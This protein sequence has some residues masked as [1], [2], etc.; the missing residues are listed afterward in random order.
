MGNGVDI[1][2]PVYNAYDEL[3]ICLESVYKY[4]NLYENRLILIND[5][6]SEEK[7]KPYLDSQQ[8]ENVF[9][10]HNEENKGFSNN[11][12]LGMA[13]SANR[14]VILLNSDTVVTKNWVEKIVKCAYSDRS[15][16]T[17]TPLSNN[18]TLCSVPNFC[19][20]NTLPEGMTIDQ[21]AAIVEEC[22]L[23]KYPR[24]TV[25][26]GFCM[27]VKREVINAIGNF[28]AEAFGRGYGE[29]NDFCNRAEQMG[30]IHVMCDDTYIYHSGTKSFVSKEKEA[31]IKEHDRILYKRY[32]QQMHKNSLHCQENPNGWVGENIAFHFDIWNGKKNIL[33]LL[34]SDFREG[35]DDNVGGT[36]LHVKHLTIGLCKD[37]NVFVAARNKDYLQVT[38]YV[39]DKE[40]VFR[41]HIG[42]KEMFPVFHDRK[43]AEIFRA[44][45]GCFRID[46]VHVHHTATT[47][48]DIYYEADR[49]GIPILFTAHDFYY[50]CPNEKLLDYEGNI[51]FEKECT[52][53]VKCLNEKKGI[54]EKNNYLSMWRK[55]HGEILGMCK[56]IFTPS[57][58][59]KEILS[60]FYPEITKK[61]HVIEHGMDKQPTLLV[62][63]GQIIYTDRLEWKIEK[64]DKRKRCP[65]ICGVAYIKYDQIEY[66]KVILKISDNKGKSIY[67][68][69]TY[70]K[71]IDVLKDEN[72]FYAYLPYTI[73][74]GRELC[75]EL[76]LY[77]N[78]KYY[79][80]KG[81]KQILKGLDFKRNCNYKVAFIGGL[82]E[83]KGAG[84]VRDI[85]KKGSTDI[86]WYVLGGIGETNL[87][88][89]KQENLIKTGYYYQEDLN[90]W[91]EYYKIDAICI[92][93]KWPE[94]F[95]YTLSEAVL[96]GIPVIATNVGALGQRTIDFGYGAVIS[97]EHAVEEALQ[98]IEAWKRRKITANNVEVLE[99]STKHKTTKD[100]LCDYKNEYAVYEKMNLKKDTS[101]II[102]NELIKNALC[103]ESNEDANNQMLVQ[104][105]GELQRHINKIE[106][107]A[108]FKVMRRVY[109]FNIPFKR[110][111]RNYILKH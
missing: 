33:Y 94:T 75:I 98:Y 5:N 77:K 97:L 82:N 72:R 8:K 111:I 56:H 107:S 48:L 43:L 6:S 47:S 24:I 73:F 1:I 69:T 99:I 95:S 60:K 96:N 104:K 23:K 78:N 88:Q 59:A 35:A 83:E 45:L 7:I 92:L 11:I 61:I 34:Q 38:A 12:N 84:I 49:L 19:E 57:N 108:A 52:D 90:T 4:T 44:I 66:G 26:H 106:N 46:I 67:L 101:F 40:H 21:A 93:S 86:E 51:C 81:K 58:S 29:E 50:V 79:M 37:M 54:C 14:D 41:F 63:E 91:L 100:M 20:E 10:I 15:I 42:E 74:E 16:G 64:I 110:Q 70:G 87:F 85:I 25:A 105:I 71:N 22:S 53:C 18:A 65:F 55:V 62:D 103:S 9:I 39:N 36:Q 76:L 80:V 89:L 17:V 27:F 31:Y 109:V 2:I 102:N 13:Q 30:Y 28:D 68:P 3:R 32:P